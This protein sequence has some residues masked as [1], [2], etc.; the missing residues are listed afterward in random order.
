MLPLVVFAI[1][2]AYFDWEVFLNILKSNSNR[3]FGVGP[4]IIF[5]LINRSIV[6]KSF[7]DGWLLF[8][9]IS[10]F[11]LAFSEWK[12]NYGSTLILS[13]ILSYLFVFIVFGSEPYGWYRY[14]LFPFLV[15]SLS[16]VL[17]RM[18]KNG[19]IYL[20]SLLMM[21]P[22]GTALNRLVGVMD[23]QPF[24]LYFRIFTFVIFSLFTA[25]LFGKNKKFAFIKKGLMLVIFALAVWLSV[26]LI[27]F[28]NI[29][30]WYFAV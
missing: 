25:S 1:Y 5:T 3:F 7:N 13:A 14:P 19:Q 15:L 2:G 21:L 26:K 9:W 12:K 24:V 6:T 10:M 4:E 30:N 22:I 18:F 20:F 23:F 27:Y 16:K 29:D 17:V 28:Y 8:C 11:I